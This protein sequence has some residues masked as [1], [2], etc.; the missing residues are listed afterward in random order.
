M[1]KTIRRVETEFA[2]KT[3]RAWFKTFNLKKVVHNL[4]YSEMKLCDFFSP[5]LHKAGFLI[6][7][8]VLT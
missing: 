5:K 6:A 3:S 4:S 1:E 8:H 7:I 2:N